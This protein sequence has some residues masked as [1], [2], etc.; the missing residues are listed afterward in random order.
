MNEPD[1]GNWY[2]L[3]DRLNHVENQV[4]SIDTKVANMQSDITGLV[5]AFNNYTESSKTNW[6]TIAALATVVLTV[7]SAILYHNS[8]S[9]GPIYVANHYQEEAIAELKSEIK[10]YRLSPNATNNPSL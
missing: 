5:N 9:L 6:G 8:L 3:N 1:S 4:T 7:I 2:K 10:E